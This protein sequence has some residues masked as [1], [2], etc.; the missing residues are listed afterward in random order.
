MTLNLVLRKGFIR[1][2]GKMGT[3]AGAVYVLK[4]KEM[5]TLKT[6]SSPNL[7]RPLP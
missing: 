2:L 4:D 1:F 5:E 6:I 7:S 3:R